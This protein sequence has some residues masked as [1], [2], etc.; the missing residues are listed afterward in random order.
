[1]STFQ[2]K[3]HK[4]RYATSAIAQLHFGVK[5][6]TLRKWWRKGFIRA[7]R[8]SE[9]SNLIFD[10]NSFQMPIEAA[11]RVDAFEKRRGVSPY[12]LRAFMLAGGV[13]PDGDSDFIYG[14][15]FAE[16]PDLPTLPKQPERLIE[17]SL[18]GARDGH[19]RRRKQTASSW[20]GC[21][22]GDELW[23]AN[24]AAWEAAKGAMDGVS[25]A[26]A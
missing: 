26:L 23:E 1:M 8:A 6:Q 20:S 13:V 4:P 16:Q 11:L 14:D 3:N 2:A 19:S 21:K 10:I 12:A 24:E 17:A 18:R 15:F 7:V 5:G 25:A 22:P 9:T